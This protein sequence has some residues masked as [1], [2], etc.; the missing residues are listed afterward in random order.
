VKFLIAY[1]AFLKYRLQTILFCFSFI[2]ISFNSYSQSRD[3]KSRI[4][5]L[6]DEIDS[7]A[8]KTQNTFIVTKYLKNNDPY[9]ETWHY[10]MKDNRIVYFEVRYVI[11]P[12]EFTEI[13]YV[14]RN[15]PI[16]MEQ[17]EAPYMAYYVDELK[18][19]KMYFIDNDAI[20]LFVTL[21]KKQNSRDDYP[22][23]GNDCI[24]KFDNRFTELQKTM[25]YLK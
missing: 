16:C 9:K 17:Y 24:A 20:R 5:F 1:Q 23:S 4:D 19:G 22:L 18:D 14:Y 3:W 11:G 21:G 12:D 6:V 15:R 7:L 8:L 2:F 10:T 13:Y 25:Q